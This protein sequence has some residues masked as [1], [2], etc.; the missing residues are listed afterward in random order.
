MRIRLFLL[1]M[2]FGCACW[3]ND[4]DAA[5]RIILSQSPSGTAAEFP[6]G[7]VQTLAFTM[8]NNNNGG[9]VGGSY[10]Q[11][12]FQLGATG[13]TFLSSTVAPL[14]WTRT[15]FSPTSITFKVI[16]A[17][18]A[19]ALGQSVVFNLVMSMGPVAAD[20]AETLTSAQAFDD[21]TNQ[22]KT[23][24]TSLGSWKRMSLA[25]TSLQITDTLGNPV[26]AITSGTSFQLRMT[27][28]N[29]SSVIQNTIVANVNPPSKTGTVTQ[30]VTSTI[31][32]P[33]NLAAGA[34]GTIIFTYST[35][36]SDNGTIS[37][38]AIARNG[39][40]VSSAT[41][42]SGILSVSS[43]VASISVAPTC[44]YAGSNVTVSM[45]V[46]NGSLIFPITSVTPTL[47]PI[48][49]AP[50]TAV[51]GPTPPSAA[52]IP[53]ASSSTTPSSTTFTW[54]YQL[55]ATGATS[56]FTFSGSASGTRNGVAI[57]TLNP[58]PSIS[59][60]PTTRG[61]FLPTV[62]PT[63]TNAGSTNTELTFSVTNNGCFAVNSVAIGI[64]AGWIAAG[65]T[66]SLVNVSAGSSIETWTASGAGPVT[67]TAP[68]VAGQMPLTFSGSFSVVFSGTP[69]GVT[70][71][72]FTLRVT[73]ANGFFADVPVNVT[74]TAFK[75]GA[76]NNATNKIW[77]EDFR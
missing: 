21:P 61:T 1:C 59:T 25:I 42:A 39:A 15:S 73:D 41:A 36:T 48:T 33:L 77:R 52:T 58:L 72:T 51:S 17:A 32:S 23:N 8:T 35:A 24:A 66:Y 6:A 71:S 49:G 45:L 65:D 27:V 7:S 30:A 47:T 53:V 22:R 50:V 28:R 63:T 3:S 20:Q 56:P 31:G 10:Y 68:N 74:L 75:T 54:I 19:I 67:F 18:N 46:S 12:R 60:P 34:S 16:S 70:I 9:D 43:F 69:A 40:T 57:S 11:M 4:A 38:T 13:T 37:F 76:L 64:P 5:R 29:N 2:L 14:G 44:Q 62:S 26:S 55:N